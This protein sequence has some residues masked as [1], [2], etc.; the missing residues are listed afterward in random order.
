MAQD[1]ATR[2]A[3]AAK[4]P[5]RPLPDADQ[6]SPNGVTAP[7]G[8]GNGDESSTQPA[9]DPKQYALQAHEW[10][11]AAVVGLWLAALGAASVLAGVWAWAVADEAHS[12]NA[13][14]HWVGPDFTATAATSA[15]VLAVV[16]GVAGSFVH[17]GS[18]FAARVG[19]RTFEV[20]Y[21]WWYLL[22]PL[23]SALVAM[24][25]VA[26]VRSGL[27]ALGAGTSDSGAAVLAFLSGA[28]AGLFTDRVMQRLR[29]LLGATKVDEK[30][31]EQLAPGTHA[32]A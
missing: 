20:S 13:A 5:A 4:S 1:D 18:L 26:A 22:R 29:G 21:F 11:V 2:P 8:A 25:F 32:T 17:A 6:P 23:E 30:A 24:I 31:T 27:V 28:L 9:P 19:R 10:L 14:V 12:A 15:L 7:G 3:K 16:G